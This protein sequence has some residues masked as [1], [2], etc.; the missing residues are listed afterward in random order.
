MAPA[1]ARPAPAS[2][3]GSWDSGAGEA[4]GRTK[5]NNR[6]VVASA[7]TELTTPEKSTRKPTTTVMVTASQ[8]VRAT[9]VLRQMNTAQAN[10]SPA[11]AQPLHHRAG[12]LHQ[13]QHRERA[14]GCE[15]R[16]RRRV[17]H[18]AA[19]C[20][21]CGHHQCSA[22]GPAG[23]SQL[24][25]MGTQ[26]RKGPPEPDVARCLHSLAHLL[27]RGARVSHRPRLAARP[28]CPSRGSRSVGRRSTGPRVS[29]ARGSASGLPPGGCTSGRD[30]LRSPAWWP[31]AVPQARITNPF[32]AW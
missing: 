3:S 11:S 19:E 15:G 10:A 14:E 5:A 18:L 17:E 27:S 24:R 26:P 25:I 32:D 13:Q 21:Q 8:V 22:C 4:T 16:R 6:A 7:R 2:R 31:A 29:S 12:E 23:R 28:V 1:A 9:S 30:R 20:E